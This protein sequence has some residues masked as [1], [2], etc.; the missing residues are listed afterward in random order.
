MVSCGAC[1]KKERPRTTQLICKGAW[2]YRQAVL[3]GGPPARGI[4]RDFA[5]GRQSLSAEYL[6][7]FPASSPIGFGR[8][9]LTAT[10]LKN[11]KPYWA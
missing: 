8:P 9:N 3:A 6:Y 11:G 4:L 5:R 1:G 7:S 2:P 10:A